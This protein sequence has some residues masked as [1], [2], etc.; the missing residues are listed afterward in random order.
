MGKKKNVHAP[1]NNV[2]IL[3][4]K[5]DFVREL[6]FHL[7]TFEEK[8]TNSNIYISKIYWHRKSNKK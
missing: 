7:L 1:R 2:R 5:N 3:K 4:K 8:K 6:F